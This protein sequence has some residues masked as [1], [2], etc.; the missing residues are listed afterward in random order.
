MHRQ[1]LFKEFLKEIKDNIDL[2]LDSL[3]IVYKLLKICEIDQEFLDAYIHKWLNHCKETQNPHQQSKLRLI[4]KLVVE[5]IERK[6][7]DPS[8]SLEVWIHFCSHFKTNKFVNE[9][10]RLIKKTLKDKNN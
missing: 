3:E 8:H 5:L 4:C 1:A 2:S 10:H 9:M 6:L 7:F